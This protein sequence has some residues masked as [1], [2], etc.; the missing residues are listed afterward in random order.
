MG[1]RSLCKCKGC[2]AKIIWMYTV[3][4]RMIPVDYK[5]ELEGIDQFD[6]KKM[7]SHFA[8]CSKASDFRKSRKK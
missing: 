3:A 8:T 7:V 1:K 6:E 4:K 2:G 5:P